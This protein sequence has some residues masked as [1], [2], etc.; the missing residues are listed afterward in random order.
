LAQ[1]NEKEKKELFIKKHFIKSIFAIVILIILG[2]IIDLNFTKGDIAY[3]DVKVE[4]N[5]KMTIE[6]DYSF[7][8]DYPIAKPAANFF[9]SLAMALAIS[10]FILQVIQR[11]EDILK[12]NERLEREKELKKEYKLR[13]EMLFKNVFKGVFDRLV[14]EEVFEVIKSDILEAKIVR[15]NV[16]WVYDF[17]PTEDGIVL[18]RNVM[19]EA[20][21]TTGTDCIETFSYIFA[22]SEHSTT[23]IK[24]LIWH[25]I[26]HIDDKSNI[27]DTPEKLT[28]L[29]SNDP[30]YNLD[31][32]KK[33]IPI[34][35]DKAM[36]IKFISEE[37]NNSSINFL[38]DTHFSSACM[39]GWELMVNI[40]E[41]YEFSI[42]PVFS[43]KVHKNMSTP[44]RH[45]YEYNGAILKGQGIEFTLSKIS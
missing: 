36:L 7:V 33:D 1:E 22:A 28:P 40:P 31:S 27:Y 30:V 42:L 29:K 41:G 23:Q 3:T 6:K 17:N 9:Y 16:K 5:G 24:S 10:L 26:D 35:K 43:G 11:D 39:I 15:R 34:A 13:E 14:P 21:N 20:H 45:R 4:I 38:H 37:K 2:F 25:E 18:I 8:Y 12:E 19:Y 44:T 32:V